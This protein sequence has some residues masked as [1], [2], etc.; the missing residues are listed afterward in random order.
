MILGG[1]Y[2]NLAGRD[3]SR[4]LATFILG[5]EAFRDTYDDLSDLTMDQMSTVKDWEAQFQGRLCFGEIPE[6]SA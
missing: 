2:D 4:A 3:A 6:I 5:P 1:A